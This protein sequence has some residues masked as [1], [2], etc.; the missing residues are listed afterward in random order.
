MA[1]SNRFQWVNTHIENN[2]LIGSKPFCRG[3]GGGGGR[4]RAPFCPF[5]FASANACKPYATLLPIVP[6]SGRLRSQLLK[7]S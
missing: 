7:S 2:K 6:G 1:K 5:P 4:V 3:G